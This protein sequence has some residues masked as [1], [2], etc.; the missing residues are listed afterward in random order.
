MSSSLGRE[1]EGLRQVVERVRRGDPHGPPIEDLMSALAAMRTV[2]EEVAGWE[3]DLVAAARRGGV[4]WGALAPVLGVAS[5]QAAERRFLRL[6]PAAT[7]D[8]T[9]EGRVRATRARRA[10]DRAVVGWARDNAA[11]LREL[12]GQ[13]GAVQ[14]LPVGGRRQAARVRAALGDDDASALLDPLAKVRTHLEDG[15]ADLAD[16][17]LSLTER[18]GRVRRTADPESRRRSARS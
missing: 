7:T 18:L 15:H 6:N 16:K 9:A 1:F 17:I 10:S 11:T 2:R 13:V 14:D 12:A 3:P 8:Q 5:R 4:T